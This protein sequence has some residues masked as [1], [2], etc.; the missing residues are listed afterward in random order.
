M[1]PVEPTTV[2]KVSG[3]RSDGAI[4][5]RVR[6]WPAEGAK[7]HG[8]QFADRGAAEAFRVRLL[9]MLGD[10]PQAAEAEPRPKAK[11][12][13]PAA[14]AKAQPKKI[15]AEPAA[16]LEAIS[17]EAY[18]GTATWW[19]KLIGELAMRVLAHAEVGDR[20]G[21][22]VWSKAARTIKELAAAQTAHRDVKRL[23][24]LLRSLQS[25]YKELTAS[26]SSGA[27]LQ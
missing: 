10:E 25:K 7:P 23:E 16:Q 19:D 20:G 21:L 18:D 15:E 3:V 12:R 6:W 27:T 9:E 14:K 22:D 17:L 11:K 2:A 8:R 4:G 24:Q 5:Y 26:A 13:K 1:R